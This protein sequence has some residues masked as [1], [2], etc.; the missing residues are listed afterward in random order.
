MGDSVTQSDGSDL[1]SDAWM[2][3][4]VDG[5]SLDVTLVATDLAMSVC[6]RYAA[7]EPFWALLHW[8]VR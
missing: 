3:A 6:G 4:E 8:H 1:A 2:A 7:C 5:G